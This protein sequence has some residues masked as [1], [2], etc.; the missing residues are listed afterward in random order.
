M[1][2]DLLS[3]YAYV[4]RR[5]LGD[6]R[7]DLLLSRTDPDDPKDRILHAIL[8]S[9]A[10]ISDDEELISFVILFSSFA[11]VTFLSCL[12][13]LREH[14]EDSP[15]SPRVPIKSVMS[16]LRVRSYE[17]SNRTQWQTHKGKWDYKGAK[18]VSIVMTT[19]H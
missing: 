16:A 9:A 1:L 6:R 14:S 3:L 11:K 13:G 4:A 12:D 18:W 7:G 2:N 5:S 17:S 15:I 10:L 8:S 19:F